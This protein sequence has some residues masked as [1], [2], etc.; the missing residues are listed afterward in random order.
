[1]KYLFRVAVRGPLPE[2]KL[3]RMDAIP[4]KPRAS[5]PTVPV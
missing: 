3:H 4:L 2:A 5:Y 1:M